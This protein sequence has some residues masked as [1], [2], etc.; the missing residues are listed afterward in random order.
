MI[1]A[2]PAIWGVYHVLLYKRDPRSAMGW[3]IVCVF[4]P[5]GGPLAYFLFGIN[6]VKMRAIGL[7]R[8]LLVVDYE[9]GEREG[10]PAGGDGLREAGRRVTGRAA[11]SGNEV[12]P[13]HNGEAAYPA[14]LASID[15]AT[16]R[17]LLSTYIL[18][19][20]DTGMAFIDALEAAVARGVETMVLID[21][22]GDM[23]S[24][25]RASS[26]L[27]RRKVNVARF[28]PP[29]LLPPSVYIN[30][31]NHRKVLIIDDQLAY[32]GGMNISDDHNSTP[33]RRRSVSDVHFCLR[34]PVV[35]ELAELFYLDWHFAGGSSPADKM[36][37]HHS[38]ACGDM[39][40]R[41]IPDG[42]AEDLD[43]LALTIQTV[44]SAASNSVDIMT[45]YFLPS[46]ELIGSLQ[47]A[48]L[49]GIKVRIILPQKNNLFYMH[50]AHRN[51]LAELLNWDIEA[52]Y[53]SAPFCHS[54]LLCIDADYSLIGSANLDPRSL[55]LNFELGIEVFS[56]TLNSEL[57][58]HIEGVISESTAVTYDDL[59]NRPVRT[60]LRDSAAA[61]FAP[62]L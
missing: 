30:L 12:N 52:F 23:Y 22:Y 46:R 8:R 45:P 2:G 60:R 38:K 41:T 56:T 37:G 35:S 34:G 25:P 19:T 62:Y 3:I 54:K 4:I 15:N 43:A 29:K 1:H 50:W 11:S 24:W 18:K 58:S 26:L 10:Q 57:R 9:I 6:R 16:D 14:M 39:R 48:A 13:L 59:K 21:G 27:R 55:R 31:R 36:S 40:C 17:V 44:I 28:L 33:P 5:Y 53:Q 7:A 49:R 32:A 47:S 42:P 61:L 51:T 20:D